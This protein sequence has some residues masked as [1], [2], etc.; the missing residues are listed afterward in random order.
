M[1]RS[2]VQCGQ[3]FVARSERGKYCSATCRARASEARARGV[4]VPDVAGPSVAD[5]SV[6]VRSVVD[7]VS[8]AGLEGSPD[9]L[10]AIRLAEAVVANDDGSKLAALSRQFNAQMD[11][12]ESLVPRVTQVDELRRRRDRKR[13]RPA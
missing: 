2:C 1:K 12:I 10:L 3:V 8:E 5:D 7:R 13:A 9:G 6:F 4:D 11:R